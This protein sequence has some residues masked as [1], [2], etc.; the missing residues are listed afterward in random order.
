MLE[1]SVS[2]AW[3]HLLSESYTDLCA[4]YNFSPTFQDPVDLVNNFWCK[5]KEAEGK[6]TSSQQKNK[7]WFVLWLDSE[8]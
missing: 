7:I 2:E 4:S 5:P 3:K 8:L 6:T 1:M